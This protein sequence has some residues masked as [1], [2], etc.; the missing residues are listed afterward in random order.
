MATINYSVKKVREENRSV[1]I[2]DN[3]FICVEHTVNGSNR[4]TAFIGKGE[5]NKG[6]IAITISRSGGIF[7]I[8]RMAGSAFFNAKMLLEQDDRNKIV[9][10]GYFK[11][12]YKEQKG[13][14][15]L[16]F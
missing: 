7:E 15:V 13:N 4:I 3:E 8:Y 2:A 14:L 16:N 11:E 12:L 10:N 1:E 6:K 9:T 5:S